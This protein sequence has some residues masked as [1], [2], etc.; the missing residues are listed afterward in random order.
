M[1]RIF[2]IFGNMNRINLEITGLTC[3]PTSK[4]AY[5]LV[6]S[7]KDGNRR[8]P[9][10]IGT[11]EASAIALKLE[12]LTS[13]R[14][15]THDLFKIVA[16]ELKFSITN[17]F[18]YKLE[19]GVFYAQ[20][21]VTQGDEVHVIDCRTSDAV[22]LATRFDCAIQTTEDILERASVSVDSQDI[23]QYEEENPISEEELENEEKRLEFIFDSVQELEE[24]L[25]Q[26][27]EKEDFETASLIRDELRSRE[28]NI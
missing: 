19:D 6:L 28:S 18:I 14:P 11:H 26:A 3:S 7:E 10:F 5:I 12:Q 13:P 22:A 16:D 8:L 2:S 24:K 15:L 23:T 1:A 17:V 21:T 9:I 25:S 4:D 27:I 20:I